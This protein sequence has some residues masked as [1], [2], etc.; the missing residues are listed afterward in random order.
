MGDEVVVSA[1]R[2]FLLSESSTWYRVLDAGDDY[3]T[4]TKASGE[5]PGRLAGDWSGQ[6]AW[7]SSSGRKKSIFLRN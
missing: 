4:T 2:G 6:P 7:L 1:W 3:Q 5:Y